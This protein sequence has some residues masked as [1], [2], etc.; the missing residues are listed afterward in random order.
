MYQNYYFTNKINSTYTISDYITCN[1]AQRVITDIT[2]TGNNIEIGLIISPTNISNTQCLWCARGSSTSTSTYTLFYISGSG[3]RWDYNSTLTETKVTAA[4]G[5]KY[6]VIG[7]NNILYVN[8]S[9]K[10][11]QT[12][13]TFTAGSVIQLMA[14]H[15]NGINANLG[16]YASYKFYGCY[17]KQNNIVV[18]KFLP[19]YNVSTNESG[20]YDV[21]NDKFYASNGTAFNKGNDRIST[22]VL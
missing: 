19:C 12:L 22:V 11:T 7:K 21:I 14:S 4:V 15:Y 2:P 16:N 5:S 13:S 8:G 1:G 20:L 17:I 9:V 10:S 18:R 3:W 6:T